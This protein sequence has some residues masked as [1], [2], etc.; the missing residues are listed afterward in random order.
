MKRI[1]DNSNI[2]IRNLRRNFEYFLKFI[3]GNKAY[4][5]FTVIYLF[6]I[7][8]LQKRNKQKRPLARSEI[9]LMRAKIPLMARYV[10]KYC[11]YYL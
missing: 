1:F 10:T 6:I 9:F 5:R 2:H 11:K 7:F 3:H 4:S 8:P